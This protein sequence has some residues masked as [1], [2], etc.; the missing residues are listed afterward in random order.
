MA[1]SHIKF[2][3]DFHIER[4]PHRKPGCIDSCGMSP[5]GFNR[6]IHIDDFADPELQRVDPG[7]MC[8][9]AAREWP[10]FQAT[11][12]SDSMAPRADRGQTVCGSSGWMSY[13]RSSWSRVAWNVIRP[14]PD[15]AV[16]EDA[17]ECL[18][19]MYLFDGRPAGWS[20][21]RGVSSS[22]MD[23]DLLGASCLA[24]PGRGRLRHI[25]SRPRL[26][27]AIRRLPFS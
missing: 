1:N 6:V 27:R 23:T 21:A 9:V 20:F 14:D 24:K 13:A 26:R 5:L 4:R 19:V 25:V 10:G 12:V 16:I 3:H 22:Q 18:P 8:P 11:L 15:K 2:Q 7:S 17:V